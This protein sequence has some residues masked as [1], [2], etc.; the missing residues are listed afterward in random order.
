MIHLD[1][2]NQKHDYGIRAATFYGHGYVQERDHVRLTESLQ[3]TY[4]AIKDEAWY[5]LAQISAVTHTPEASVSANIRSLRNPK[6]GGYFI[7][8]NHTRRGLYQYRL[9]HDR[10]TNY[11][12]KSGYTSKDAVAYRDALQ[13]AKTQMELTGYGPEHNVLMTILRGALER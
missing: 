8:R 10:P 12:P 7:E 4:D 5:T 11:K 9:L 2:K 1:N 3:A 13:R 6:N